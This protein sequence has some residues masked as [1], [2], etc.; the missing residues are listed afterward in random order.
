MFRMHVLLTGPAVKPLVQSFAE[1]LYTLSRAA[2]YAGVS[3][4]RPVLGKGR[5]HKLLRLARSLPLLETGA[6]CYEGP[7]PL[8][9]V[10]AHVSSQG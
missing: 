5:L 3:T 2:D 7:S 6:R 8:Q 4:L 9:A 10:G 1:N